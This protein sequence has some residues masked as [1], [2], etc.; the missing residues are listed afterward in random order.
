MNILSFQGQIRSQ[1]NMHGG[2]RSVRQALAR[3]HGPLPF[4]PIQMA[5]YY[6]RLLDV[7][8]KK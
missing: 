4:P 6:C 3:G 8:Y 1:I 7:R 5:E 2:V